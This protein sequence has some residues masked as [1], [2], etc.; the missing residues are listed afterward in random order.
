MPTLTLGPG[1]Q[2][3]PWQAATTAGRRIKTGS[4]AAREA[5]AWVDESLCLWECPASTGLLPS[6]PLS[7]ESKW[8]QQHQVAH[9]GALQ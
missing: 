7:L 5:P 3:F 1:S 2:A 6:C 8:K 4:P 9:G